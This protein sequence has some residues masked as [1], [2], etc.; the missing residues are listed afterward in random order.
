MSRLSGRLLQVKSKNVWAHILVFNKK[1]LILGEFGHEE[2]GVSDC[3][4]VETWYAAHNRRNHLFLGHWATINNAEKKDT[5]AKL[6]MVKGG[7]ELKD[8]NKNEYKTPTSIY[9]V[10]ECLRLKRIG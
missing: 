7:F 9:E 6:K 10:S 1:L 3:V 5:N 8:C 4:A 2:R